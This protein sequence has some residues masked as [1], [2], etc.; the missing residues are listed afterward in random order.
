[1]DNRKNNGGARKGAGRKKGIGLSYDIQKHCNNFIIELLKD[2]TIKAKA[3]KQ[4]SL[5]FEEDEEDY[6]YIIRN[7][8]YYKIGYSSNWSKRY[9]NY[10][11]HSGVVDLVY[12]SKQQDSFSLEA[13]LHNLFKDKRVNGEWFDLSNEDVLNAISYC[14]S[15]IK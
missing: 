15:T 5:M 4:M 8:L 2:E 1:M 10:K 6:L 12:L 11:T 3:L 14:S 9:K 7:G 13:Y